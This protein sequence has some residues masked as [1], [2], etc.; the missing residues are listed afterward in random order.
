MTRADRILY[1]GDVAKRSEAKP[2]RRNAMN[3]IAG[4][5]SSDSLD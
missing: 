4:E 1:L 2:V 5:S 3:L